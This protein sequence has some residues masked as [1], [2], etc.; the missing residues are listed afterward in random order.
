MRGLDGRLIADLNDNVSATTSGSILPP[1]TSS[2][3]EN[4]T[5]Y[6]LLPVPIND[7][8]YIRDSI[9]DTS[10]PKIKPIQ[11]NESNTDNLFVDSQGVVKVLVGT[12]FRLRMRASQPPI[13]N[14]ENGK[15]TLIVDR[16]PLPAPP[17]PGVGVSFGSPESVIEYAWF[18]DDSEILNDV[19]LQRSGSTITTSGPRGEELVFRNV[20]PNFAGV[21]T[22]QASNDIGTVESEQITLEVYNA[23]IE[24]AFYNN[25]I[26]NPYGKEGT[27]QWSSPNTEF[28]AA[29]FT[30]VPFKDISQPWNRDVFAY[31]A[32]MLYPRPYHINTY[33]IKNSNF[34]EDLLVEGAYFTRDR[35][36]YRVKDGQAIINAECDID[37]LEIADYTKGAV[38]GVE[39]VRAVFGAYLGNAVSRYRNTITTALAE[40]RNF[41]NTVDT[42]KPRISKENCLLAG[43]P[44][45]DEKVTVTVVEMDGETPLM[46]RVY[47]MTTGT[48]SNQPG[49]SVVDPWQKRIEQTPDIQLYTSG[50][51]ISVG[52]K[53][54][55]LI[56]IAESVLPYPSQDY[57]ATYAQFAE[58][59]KVVI[60]RLNFKTN[61]IRITVSFTT[62]TD[63]I[64]ER[65]PKFLDESDECFEASPW[66]GMALTGKFPQRWPQDYY[67]NPD[68]TGV[69]VY[70]LNRLVYGDAVPVKQ[71][72]SL[73]GTPRSLATG[74][75]LVLFPIEKTDPDKVEYFTK[76]LLE[77]NINSSSFTA[78]NTSVSPLT[79]LA[80]Y[81]ASLDYENHYIG[82]H[83]AN[84]W[85]IPHR[86][87]DV[88]EQF[89]QLYS[90]HLRNVTTVDGPDVATITTISTFK[91]IS[92]STSGS[93]ASE[94]Y[95]L[96]D[97]PKRNWAFTGLEDLDQ[98]LSGSVE[99]IYFS[100]SMQ[101]VMQGALP[102]IRGTVQS[103]IL[104][105]LSDGLL[106]TVPSG[107]VSASILDTETYKRN[108][109]FYFDFEVHKHGRGDLPIGTDTASLFRA[110][111]EPDPQWTVPRI[112]HKHN[113]LQD[114]TQ[115][116]ANIAFIP[117]PPAPTPPEA[118]TASG[119]T[120]ALAPSTGSPS[121]PGYTSY[122]TLTWDPIV[123][124][125]A[126]NQP[127][128]SLPS[129][130]ASYLLNDTDGGYRLV[131][132]SDQILAVD[133]NVTSSFVRAAMIDYPREA[134]NYNTAIGDF[135]RLGAK[136]ILI[137]L[138]GY[139]PG[140]S[141]FQGP[142]EYYYWVISR[143]GLNGYFRGGLD[144]ATN[145]IPN[146][147][148]FTD[149]LT[150]VPEATVLYPG[151]MNAAATGSN[152][153]MDAAFSGL[154][155]T[156]LGL[157]GWGNFVGNGV[158]NANGYI[159]W[160]D[161]VYTMAGYI[162]PIAGDMKAWPYTV[163]D[164]FEITATNTAV[165][166]ILNGNIVHTID[167][168]SPGSILRCA[169]KHC[170]TNSNTLN[171][172]AGPSSPISGL[173]NVQ[174]GLY[175]PSVPLSQ[176]QGFPAV[177]QSTNTGWLSVYDEYEVNNYII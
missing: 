171:S 33:H 70:D 158:N 137:G 109:G 90:D 154:D 112:R 142:S 114:I 113:L 135:W 28:K 106:A 60:E 177:Y 26:P 168:V 172:T 72:Y 46:S 134:N 100:G 76:T 148:P 51:Y 18:K 156:A 83:L 11:F 39:G 49:I 79:P 85:R 14:V 58:W 74:F 71:F 32:D 22:C 2:L 41:R 40:F 3:N 53:E 67:T 59:N 19:D 78:V 55:K 97:D 150:G 174:Y 124:Q 5:E 8:P 43:V 159:D 95:N 31:T 84:I 164:L 173:T 91:Y 64:D 61:K 167:R 122:Y 25:L 68:G 128:A 7:P 42:T 152:A 86:V 80:Q 21:Y 81:L 103:G 107:Y 66:E 92:G 73:L 6:V 45:L 52:S 120:N 27:D 147:T 105:Y 145:S 93:P 37:L 23:D 160:L 130:Q 29:K 30:N 13:Y 4:F 96:I 116:Y 34:T 161:E 126:M 136:S 175:D 166:F 132:L 131:L 144:L 146:S 115:D 77:P 102:D 38:Y 117:A 151:S 138:E 140:A 125:E 12:S 56:Y 143:S 98:D 118:E 165:N 123:V 108:L 111:K 110:W 48:S 119:T 129:S 88:D 17:N 9:Y 62:S 87:F 121:I 170:L 101:P 20:S 16:I 127:N 153:Y 176:Q 99:V 149:P 65:W 10:S 141:S 162:D 157:E 169:A 139:T 94:I 75:N 50:S 47:D 89:N 69:S 163:S 57:I 24:D 155:T 104:N 63:L 35:F 15:P 44:V 54:E 133:N 36:K 82:V 1:V